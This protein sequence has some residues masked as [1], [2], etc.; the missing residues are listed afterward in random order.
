MILLIIIV[1]IIIIIIII[2]II[3]I[4]VRSEV[5]G[6]IEISRPTGTIV[7]KIIIINNI[8]EI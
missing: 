1:T 5:I 6:L 2:I 8:M 3:S 4:S 7:I